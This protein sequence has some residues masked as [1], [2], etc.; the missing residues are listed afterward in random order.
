MSVNTIHAFCADLIHERPVEAGVEPGFAV[1]DELRAS[2]IL[3]EAWEAWLAEQMSGDSPAVRRAVESGISFEAAGAR[4]SPV[5]SLACELIE[6]RDAV[7][8]GRVE[9]PWTDAQFAEAAEALREPIAELAEARRQDCRRPE[10]DGCAG[11]IAELEG[12]ESI[13][14]A[15]GGSSNRLDPRVARRRAGHQG[16]LGTTGQLVLAGRPQVREGRRRGA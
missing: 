5:F 15:Q 10:T 2:L 4:E 13:A 1:A 16:Q 7:A 6:Q 8:D 14:N 9:T 12:V 11:Q 3:E